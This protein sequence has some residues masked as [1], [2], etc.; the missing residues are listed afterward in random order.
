MSVNRR[1]RTR[2]TLFEAIDAEGIG[3]RRGADAALAS[4]MISARSAMPRRHIKAPNT[5]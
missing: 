1:W 2:I 3:F 4:T 5:G